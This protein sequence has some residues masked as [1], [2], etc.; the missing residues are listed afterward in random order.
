MNT[1]VIFLIIL[2]STI[3]IYLIFLSLGFLLRKKNKKAQN[4]EE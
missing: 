4:I 2:S 3:F 1:Q